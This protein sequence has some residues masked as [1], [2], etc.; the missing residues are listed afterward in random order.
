LAPAKSALNASGNADQQVYYPYLVGYLAFYAGDH[1]RAIAELG[2]S[3][4]EDPFILSLMAQAHEKLGNQA[5]AMELYKQILKINFHG[6]TNAFARPLAQQKMG[7][8][9]GN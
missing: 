2:N 1:A 4:L 3:D 6:P 5:K 8:R 7:G 9:S